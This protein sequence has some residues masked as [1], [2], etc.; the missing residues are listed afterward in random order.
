MQKNKKLKLI[1]ITTVPGSLRGLLKGQLSFMTEYFSVI[2]ISSP[3]ETLAEVA[4]QEGVLS[5]GVPMKRSISPFSDLV[6]IWRLYKIF[7]QEQ[8]DI[9]HTHTPKAGTLGMIAA[10]IAKVPLRLHTVAGL[11]LLEVKGAKRKILDLVEK[12]TYR[13]ATKIYPNSYGLLEIIK[14]NKYTN[15]EKLKVIGKGS[16]NGIDTSYFD[17]QLYGE[18]K[19]LSLRNEYGINQNDH[20]FIFV[21]RIVGDKGVNELISAFDELNRQYSNIKLLILGRYEENLDPLLPITTKLIREN[22]NIITVGYQKDVRPFFAIADV[23]SFPSYREGFP[24]VVMQAA[25]MSLP[26]IVSDINGCNEIIKNGING[27][28][29]PPKD[30]QALFGAMK[31]SIENKELGKKMAGLTRDM[32]INNYEQ[33]YVW[34]EILKEY[35]S[36]NKFTC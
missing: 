10:R 24:N 25:A 7:K 30:I 13:L 17:P 31:S 35:Y 21:G 18:Q 23:L 28:V 11:P 36:F 19:K 32:M 4:Q 12:I 9:V 20:V 8:P 6:A 33:K 5:Y 16:S 34:K 26:C 2:A 22:S 14:A 3:G 15:D 27:I 1:R 29:V